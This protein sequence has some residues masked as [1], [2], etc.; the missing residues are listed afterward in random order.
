MLTQPMP[1]FSD[2]QGHTPYLIPTINAPESNFISYNSGTKSFIIDPKNNNEC[3]SFSFNYKLTDTN[4]DTAPYT[5]NVL[6]TNTA[7]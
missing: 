1:A 7:P 3:G 2:P 4:K 6:V 5:M